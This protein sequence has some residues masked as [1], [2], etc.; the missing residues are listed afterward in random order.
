M[1]QMKFFLPILLACVVVGCSK[2]AELDNGAAYARQGINFSIEQKETRAQYSQDNWLQVVWELNDELKVWCDKTQ[3]PKDGNP[4]NTEASNWAKRNNAT[5]KVTKLKNASSPASSQ[6]AEAEIGPKNATT[7]KLY[8]ASDVHT[9]YYGYGSA[10]SFKTPEQGLIKCEYAPEQTLVYNTS[11]SKWINSASLYLAGKFQT[12]PTDDV[13]L[14]CKP[15]MTTLEVEISGMSSAVAYREAIYISQIKVTVPQTQDKTYVESGKTYFDYDINSWTAPT[16]SAPAQETYTFKFP[17]NALSTQKIAVGGK[18]T[19]TL[20][21]PPIAL[22]S[23]EELK[24]EVASSGWGAY[25]TTIKNATINSGEKHK[26]QTPAWKYDVSTSN[27]VDLGLSVLWATHNV[28]GKLPT[29]IGGYYAWGET[30]TKGSYTTGNST[31]NAKSLATLAS[32]GIITTSATETSGTYIGLPKGYLTSNYDA[33][34]KNMGSP[35]RMPRRFEFKELVDNCDLIYTTLNGVSGMLFKSKIN[36][37][38]IFMTFG[39]KWKDSTTPLSTDGGHYWSSDPANYDSESTPAKEDAWCFDV[40]YSSGKIA[41]KCDVLY[42]GSNC[43]YTY[44]RYYGRSVRGV[45][46]KN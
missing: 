41:C 22:A 28:G 3:Y 1:K 15:I 38:C 9:F 16:V 17:D 4:G 33:A 45:K 29:D 14:P 35:W 31:T 44:N 20:I 18:L 36:G 19:V 46:P 42:I 25:S 7:D 40:N 12:V 21:L 34:T 30:S 43:N 32:A 26:L 23:S 13:T 27:Y 10:L 2:D 37:N 39:G 8:W 11:N 24:V 5:Y 6:N